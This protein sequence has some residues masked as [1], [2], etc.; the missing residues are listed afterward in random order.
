MTK[1]VVSVSKKP[2]SSDSMEI[3]DGSNS[4]LDEDDLNS[5]DFA[6]LFEDED[7]TTPY[8][9]GLL[10]FDELC[11]MIFRE[12]SERTLHSGKKNPSLL[13]MNKDYCMIIISLTDY[14][15]CEFLVIRV[16]Y[17]IRK[18]YNQNVITS[19]SKAVLLI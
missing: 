8:K 6:E 3:S 4:D 16:I 2:D 11:M 17:F 13:R 15:L 14:I 1:I 5:D 12:Y 18:E 7:S 19:S 9:E 10:L